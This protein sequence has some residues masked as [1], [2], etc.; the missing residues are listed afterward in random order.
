MSN[1]QSQSHFLVR[2]ICVFEEEVV[3]DQQLDVDAVVGVLLQTLIKEIPG[4]ARDVDVGR[5]ANLILDNFDEFLLLV[6]L[7]G[8]LAD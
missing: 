8:I 6:D 2:F 7:E 3:V 5:D 4:F 1:R